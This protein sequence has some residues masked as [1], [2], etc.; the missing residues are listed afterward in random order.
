M[1]NLRKFQACFP[2]TSRT[3]RVYLK[4]H[5]NNLESL[6][7]DNVILGSPLPNHSVKYLSLLDVEI[8]NRGFGTMTD[9]SEFF[10]HLRSLTVPAHG[11]TFRDDFLHDSLEGLSHQLRCIKLDLL[12]DDFS[13][14]FDPN[15][16]NFLQELPNVVE[17]SLKINSKRVYK[18]CDLVRCIF[19]LTAK[20]NHNLYS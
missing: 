19:R 3:S 6:L 11:P 16:A 2:C 8:I 4:L 1:P 15:L 7:I 18:R 10:P 13:D 9:I 14:H 17:I 5:A 12:L 20:S